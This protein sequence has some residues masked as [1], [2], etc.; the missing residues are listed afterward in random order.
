MKLFLAS[1]GPWKNDVLEKEFLALLS[2]P[3]DQNKLFILSM[4][5]TSEFHVK[6][7]QIAK[8]WYISKGFQENN[9]NIFNLKKDTIPSLENLAVLHMWGGNTFHYLHRIRETGLIPR[10]R[11]FIERDGV[12]VG[13]SAGSILMGPDVDENFTT[14]VNDIGLEDVSG[15]RYLDF[16]LSVHW[17]TRGDDVHTGFIKHSWKT[18]KRVITL[19]DNQAILLRENGFKII[20]P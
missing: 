8:E 4:D 10:I 6:H 19:T 7:L 5:T 15:L 11:A 2:K 1:W 20:S 18:G 13:F 16:N 12:Y 14:D 9:I 17:D 3:I